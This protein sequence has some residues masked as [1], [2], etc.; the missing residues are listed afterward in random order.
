MVPHR[1]VVTS[2]PIESTRR[3]AVEVVV[4]CDGA[5]ATWREVLGGLQDEADLSLRAGLRLALA[6]APFPAFFWETSPVSQASLDGLFGCVLVESPELSRVRADPEPFARHFVRPDGP[7]IR[8]FANLGRDALLVV[9]FPLGPHAPYAHLASFMREG[10]P[11][12]VDALWRRTG[13]VVAGRLKRGAGRVW[14][15]TSGLGVSWVHVRLD[16]RPKYITWEAF[17]SG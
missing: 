9:P 4:D 11:A 6:D 15:S 14:V 3:R 5:R 2:R 17:R 12:Q 1:F 8:S 10:D 16:Q 7:P 13:R